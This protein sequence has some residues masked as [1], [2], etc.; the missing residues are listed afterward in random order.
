[1][2]TL[3]QSLRPQRYTPRC[4]V[5]AAT[6]RMGAAKAKA[7]EQQSADQV[8]KSDRSCPLSSP[9]HQCVRSES[10]CVRRIRMRP[11]PVHC[12][13]PTTSTCASA[14]PAKSKDAK[15]LR[16]QSAHTRYSNIR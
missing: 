13:H 14:S 11:Q 10:E 5:V 9:S 6:D 1:M 3:L 16:T 7:S 4:Y 15:A 2:L 12:A 8:G